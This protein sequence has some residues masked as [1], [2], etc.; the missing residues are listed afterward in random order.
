MSNF[1]CIKTRRYSTLIKRIFEEY[2]ENIE[3]YIDGIRYTEKDIP[4]LLK[5]LCT[6]NMLKRT[7]NFSISQGGVKLFGFHDTPDEFWAAISEQQFVERLV[8]EKIVRYKRFRLKSKDSFEKK[9]CRFFRNIFPK[10]KRDKQN[11]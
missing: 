6:N 9:W 2:N 7:I 1:I 8:K 10:D 11:Q 3:I 5:D 4:K